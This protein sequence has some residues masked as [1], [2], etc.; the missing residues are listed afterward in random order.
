MSDD[1]RRLGRNL[2]V[3][4][5]LYAA[6]MAAVYGFS[7]VNVSTLVVFPVFIL[8]ILIACLES[9]SGIWGAVL[10]VLY[11][12]SYDLFFTVPYYELKII[13]RTD[14]IAL[15]LFLLVALIMSSVTHRM[16][17][18]VEVAERNALIMGR[19]NK[20]SAGLI[21]SR[22]SQGA[23]SYA[24]DFLT[25][26]LGREVRLVLGEP[27]AELGQAARDCYQ[28]NLPA[29]YGVPG[30]RGCTTRYLPLST[31]GRVY[32]VAA[33]DCAKGELDAAGSSFAGSVLSQ[34]VVAIE[35][36]ELDEERRLAKLREEQERFKTLLLQ[37]VSHD[38]RTPLTSI[39]GNAELL[40]QGPHQG[41]ETETELLRGIVEDSL[42]LNSMVENLLAM[43]RVQDGDVSLQKEPELADEIVGDAMAREE[44]RK[45]AHSLSAQMPQE[46]LLVPMDGKLI[47]QVIVN[48]IDNAFKHT[49]A[50]S[51]VVVSA[52]REGGRAFFE[53]ADDGGGIAPEDLE[54]VFSRFYAA[55]REDGGRRGMGLGLSICRAIVEAH[56]GEMSARNNNC[57]GASFTFWLPL[58]EPAGEETAD[59]AAAE[60]SA[61]SEDE[62]EGA[63]N[64][65]QRA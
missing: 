49:R 48:L 26:A 20:L 63:G 25:R 41:E 51:Q 37:S 30:Y 57:G 1:L 42:W 60:G 46:L 54:R 12:V 27:A 24:E 32:G 17:V 50:D 40:L 16:R 58:D 59:A 3:L 6:G 61:G 47:S 10:G 65:G 7:L 19:L 21:D 36:N 22:S 45:G 34:T 39:A 52:W 55:D 38:L 11:L 2:A 62:G 43:S 35:R 13:S 4:S 9:D 33:I 31:R 15:V 14:I 56:G 53:V 18:Q 23:C 44:R 5:L 29:G 8:G 64:G 28:G